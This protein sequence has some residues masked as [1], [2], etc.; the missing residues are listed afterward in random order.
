MASSRLRRAS[1]APEVFLLNRVTN[2]WALMLNDGVSRLLLDL[3]L[4]VYSFF[5]RAIIF[6]VLY[7]SIHYPQ[8]LGA[9]GYQCGHLGLA[10]V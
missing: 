5:E 6:F 2:V 9:Q 8:Y 10:S 1:R 4:R 7:H 3:S